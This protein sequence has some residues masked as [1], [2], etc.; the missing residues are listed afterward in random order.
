MGKMDGR[1]VVVTGANGKIGQAMA[2]A[3]VREGATVV[4]V[5]RDSER[6]SATVAN[7]VR[8]CGADAIDR[9][10]LEVVDVSL[11]ASVRDFASRWAEAHR[12]CHVLINNAAYAPPDRKVTAEGIEVQFATNVLGYNWM[13][14]ALLPALQNAT[15]KPARV[16]NVASYW[17]GGLD[18]SDLQFERMRRYDNDDAYRQSKQANRMLARAWSARLPAAQIVVHSCHPGDVRSQLS[19]M[20]GF[21]GHESPEQG[22]A[23]PVLLATGRLGAD[24][25]GKYFEHGKQ[26][27]CP[28]S[29]AQAEVDSLFEYCS[30]YGLY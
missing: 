28:F 22:A 4:L 29:A 7:V 10:S 8:A 18:L 16:V 3:M 17:A 24:S 27:A 11:R 15:P 30:Q 6:G 12:P 2:E 19:T 14:E 23:T 20:L 5:C 13:L 26:V 25:T 21:G 1:T 9:V